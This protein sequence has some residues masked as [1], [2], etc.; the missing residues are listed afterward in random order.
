MK[1]CV[2]TR[3]LNLQHINTFEFNLNAFKSSNLNNNHCFAVKI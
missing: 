3:M 2:N 1:N